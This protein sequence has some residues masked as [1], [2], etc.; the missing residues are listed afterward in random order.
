MV[1]SVVTAEADELTRLR[2]EVASLRAELDRRPPPRAGRQLFRRTTAALLAAVTAVALVTSV[3]GLWAA[4]TTLNTDRYVAT[5][6][7]LP[8]DPQ[9]SAAVAE[10]ATTAL[11]QVAD[12]EQRLRE[13]LPPRAAFVAGPLAGQIRGQVRQ[14]VTDVLRSDRFQ[15]VWVEM[16]R[17]VHQQALS[18]LEGDSEVVRVGDDRIHVDLLPLINQVLREANAELPDLFG[19]QITLPDLSSGAIP[20]DLRER[21]QE[22]LGVPLP[23]NFAQFTV[24]DAGRLRAAQEALVTAKR[25]LALFVVAT[26]VLL[27]G[28]YAVSPGRRRTTVQLGLWLVVAA[29]LVVAV[30]RAVR[31]E[32]LA[33]VPA[34]T[35]RDGVDAAMTSIVSVLRDR[36]GQIVV[37]GA[38]VALVAYL[39]GPGRLPVWV[40]SRS[41][42]AGRATA[43]GVRAGAAVLAAHGPGWI[44]AHLDPLRIAGVVVAAILA[45]ILSSW[46]SLLAVLLTLAGYEVLVTLIGRRH[47]AEPGTPVHP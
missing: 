27:I 6:A 15:P 42:L 32:I 41:A 10:Y 8:R 44:A 17:R 4:R 28:A 36:G 24:Y 47:G 43:R 34:G 21:V 26:I 19:K 16:N 13:V 30:L 11:F 14:L 38:A 5:V 25:D 46:T 31:H 29:V 23:A 3:V 2:A 45:L 40:R 22:Q 9:V 33:R 18:I 12:V 7:P 20:A 37:I 39:A 35:Y 1:S